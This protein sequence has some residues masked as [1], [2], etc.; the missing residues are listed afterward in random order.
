VE[1]REAPTRRR[2]HG[3]EREELERAALTTH[4]E[5]SGVVDEASERES[6]ELRERGVNPRVE[7]PRD[8]CLL[9]DEGAGRGASWTGRLTRSVRVYGGL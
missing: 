6:C 4:D 5:L 3:S 8:A 2:R 7:G 1:G 9:G